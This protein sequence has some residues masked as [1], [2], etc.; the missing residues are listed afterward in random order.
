VNLVFNGVSQSDTF[1]FTPTGSSV[2][3]NDT[4]ASFTWNFG[5]A[6]APA[7][8]TSV[9]ATQTHNYAAAGKYVYDL[10]ILSGIGCT[11]SLSISSPVNDSRT[12]IVL[13]NRSATP[14][15]AYEEDFE[16]NTGGGWVPWYASNANF[17]LD[18]TAATPPPVPSWVHPGA[19]SSIN[20][21]VIKNVTNAFVDTETKFWSTNSTN[22]PSGFYNGFERSALYSPAFD[23]SALKA[24]MISFDAISQ[25][26]LSDGVIVEYSQ[27]NKNITDPTKV[28]TVLGTNINEGV[29]WFADKGISA[30]PGAQT[31]ND[32]GWTGATNT[33]WISPKHTVDTLSVTGGGVLTNIVFRF[34]LASNKSAPDTEGFGVDNVRIGE[35]TRTILL[36]S[37][38]NTGNANPAEAAENAFVSG[39]PGS[40]VGTK[41]VKI[42]YHVNFPKDDP[43]NL[44]NPTDPSSRASFYSVS[45]TPES[46]L[47]GS[48]DPDGTALSNWGIESYGKRSLQLAQADLSVIPTSQ[49]GKI[50]ID[51]DV[52]AKLDIPANTVLHIAIVEDSV[53]KNSLSTVQ[54]SLVL[55]GENGFARI[56]KK[57][58]PSASGTKF[59]TPLL[60]GASRSFGP[61]EYIRGNLYANADDLTIIAFL[62][63]E[64]GNR[65]IYQVTDTT[66]FADPSLVTGLEPIASELV[67]AYPNPAHHELTVQLPGALSKPAALNLIDQTGRVALRATMQEGTDRKTLNVSDLSGGIYILTVD[68][69]QGVLTRK[70]VMIVHQD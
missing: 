13:P 26:A 45:S 28:W 53:A 11:N 52:I 6:T 27:D 51:V 70:K 16:G 32:F 40:V 42:N 10:T 8:T 23:L 36:E 55:S 20:R 34:A 66:G 58:L 50:V 59:G 24:P 49:P 31:G 48:D 65:E 43:F 41:V 22:N 19:G 37:F 18:F 17:P 44:D 33:N 47:D 5:D 25:L 29:D 62:Q 14:S 1:N 57:M 9:T 4:F 35:R 39:F 64:D 61:F 3:T 69:G 15:T 7:V 54:Q 46:R 12:L 60:K 21:T 30:K 38:M 63:R 2:S 68:M 56:L 67:L